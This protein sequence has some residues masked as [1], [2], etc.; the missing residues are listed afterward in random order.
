MH[1]VLDNTVAIFIFPIKRLLIDKKKINLHNN[2]N[3]PQKVEDVEDKIQKM[4]NKQIV[5]F[6]CVHK[7]DMKIIL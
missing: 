1:D 3:Q 7:I 6:Q 4:K 5:I 2:K